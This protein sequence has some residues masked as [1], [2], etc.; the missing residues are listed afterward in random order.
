MKWKEIHIRW[1]GIF[2]IAFLAMWYNPKHLQE[3]PFWK[4]YAISISFTALYWNG[5]Y[6]IISY[7]RRRFPEISKTKRR[8]IFTSL[9]MTVWMSL[10]GIPLKVLFHIKTIEEVLKPDEH[11]QFLPFNFIAGLFVSLCYEA[12][13]F[14]G[15]WKETFRLNEELKSRQIKTQYEVLQNQMSPH[16][17]F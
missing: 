16:F 7:F 14:F 10:G 6:F 1:I 3:E 15:K 2:C 11:T 17:L 12:F 9:I 4:V 5:A 13:Y 8:L